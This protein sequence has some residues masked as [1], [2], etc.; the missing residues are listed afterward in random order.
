[1]FNAET[2]SPSLL[3]IALILVSSHIILRL[4]LWPGQFSLVDHRLLLSPF[5]IDDLHS[6]FH[7]LFFQMPFPLAELMHEERAEAKGTNGP[8]ASFQRRCCIY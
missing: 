5:P 1:M 4:G 8:A 7:A 6:P 2:D 3:Y